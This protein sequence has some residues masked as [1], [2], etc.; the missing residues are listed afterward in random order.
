MY[1]MVLLLIQQT[2]VACTS[3]AQL[4]PQQD[5]ILTSHTSFVPH[6]DPRSISKQ[7]GPVIPNIVSHRRIW[8]SLRMRFQSL[9]SLVGAHAHDRSGACTRCRDI[10]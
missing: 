5:C 2:F 9:D 10:T 7:A 3:H 4:S 8:D 1:H 6:A